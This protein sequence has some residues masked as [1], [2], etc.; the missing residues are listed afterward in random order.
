[1]SANVCAGCY[2][3]FQ[4]VYSCKC[5]KPVLFRELCHTRFFFF[6]F[7]FALC[8]THAWGISE[9]QQKYYKEKKNEQ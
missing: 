9:L 3:L 7:K 6:F 2:S 5:V 1:M 4:R 8:A